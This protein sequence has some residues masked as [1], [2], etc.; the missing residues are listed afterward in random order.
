MIPWF[1]PKPPSREVS[2]FQLNS[3]GFPLKPPVRSLVLSTNWCTDTLKPKFWICHSNFQLVVK[4]KTTSDENSCMCTLWNAYARI[5][6]TTIPTGN[7]VSYNTVIIPFKPQQSNSART[8][9]F[10]S[11][12]GYL[13]VNKALQCRILLRATLLLLPETLMGGGGGAY[14]SDTVTCLRVFSL[15]KCSL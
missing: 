8:A 3:H 6:V 7:V 15:R 4:K 5:P 9:S 13:T 10:V 11:A 1:P 14:E 2:R 12:L